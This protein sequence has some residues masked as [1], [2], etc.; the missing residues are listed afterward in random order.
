MPNES[1]RSYWKLSLTQAAWD[2]SKM[3]LIFTSRQLLHID[4]MTAR[5]MT[6]KFWTKR[7]KRNSYRIQKNT[8]AA[9]PL[10]FSVFSLFCTSPFFVASS[11]CTL[12]EI[13]CHFLSQ[14]DLIMGD[15]GSN[16]NQDVNLTNHFCRN[17]E[18]YSL[19]EWR[20]QSNRHC[21]VQLFADMDS[22]G[23]LDS[24]LFLTPVWKRWVTVACTLL[25]STVLLACD[26]VKTEERINMTG[27]R[28]C[29]E[30]EVV[31]RTV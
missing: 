20:G 28:G 4:K 21:V 22:W 31:A 8:S 25:A 1:T 2:A 15:V 16:P 5:Y 24:L 13:L 6:L 19:A 11:C 29:Y 26:S 10:S 12:S 3:H 17:A 30:N 9:I 23:T 14:R 18:L 7:G 27:L